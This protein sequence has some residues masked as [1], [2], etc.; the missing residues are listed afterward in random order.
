[1][2]HTI[3]NLWNGNITPCESCGTT[4]AEIE[5][6]V[7]LMERNRDDLSKGLSEHQKETLAKYMDCADEYMCFITMQAFSDGFCLA[8]KLLTEALM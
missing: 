1:M 8:S 7:R 6:L 2:K 4:N 3:E 5:E